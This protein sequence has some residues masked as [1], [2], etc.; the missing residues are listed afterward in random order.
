MKAK[1]VSALKFISVGKYQTTLYTKQ[2]TTYNA[3]A[4]G[5]IVTIALII[6]MAW[7]IIPSLISLIRESHMNMDVTETK[8]DS[9]LRNEGWDIYPNT[10]SCAPKEECKKF[11][12]RD[13]DSTYDLDL[14]L[15]IYTN[16]N[17]SDL[18]LLL[19]FV[20]FGDHNFP[21]YRN[22]ANYSIPDCLVQLRDLNMTANLEEDVMN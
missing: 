3:S 9:Y 11:L 20:D 22:Y 19:N 21:G 5:G 16:A 4:L 18:T 6:T 17:C 7:L 14:T 1:V 10:T 2:G 8:I 13:L 12:I 15:A